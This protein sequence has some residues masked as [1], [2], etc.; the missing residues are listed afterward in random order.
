MIDA[1][2]AGEDGVAHELV[3]RPAPELFADVRAVRFDGL[4]AEVELF[5]DL[6]MRVALHDELEDLELAFAQD[7]EACNR[8]HVIAM[9][10]TIVGRWKGR[11]VLMPMQERLFEHLELLQSNFDDVSVVQRSPLFDDGAIDTHTIAAAEILD[12]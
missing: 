1:Q 7:F 2:H 4:H 11:E 8:R 5:G 6:S 10:E 9:V 12:V 3:A